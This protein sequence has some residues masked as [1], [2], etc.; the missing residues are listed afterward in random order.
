MWAAQY[1]R[2]SV[3]EVLIKGGANMLAEDEVCDGNR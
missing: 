2:C 1:N 3:A